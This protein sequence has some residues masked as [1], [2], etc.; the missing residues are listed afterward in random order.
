MKENRSLRPFVKWAGGKRA[1]LQ[2]IREQLPRDVSRHTYH[3]PFLGA[4]AVF[5]D[6]MPRRAVINDSNA[7][8][9]PAYRIIRDFAEDLIGILEAH[10]KNHGEKYY[11]EIRNMDRDGER[12]GKL[13]DVQRAARLIYLNKTCYNGLYRVNSRGEF[14]VPMGRYK[15]PAICEAGLLRSISAYLKESDIVIMNDDFEAALSTADS[16][17]FVYLDPPYQKISS[18]SFT[19]YQP[20][21]FGEGEQGR[22]RD[23]FVRLGGRG[24]KC[25]ESNSDTSLIRRLYEPHGFYI[26]PVSAGRRINSSVSGRGAVQEVLIRNYQEQGG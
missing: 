25:L 20:G 23:L 21:G 16:G 26:I 4:G 10:A 5:F 8:L 6:L 12:F 3:E 15:N 2:R 9:M 17:S 14:N 19:S 13:N 18:T 24:V 11:Y 7:E 1:L 22:L